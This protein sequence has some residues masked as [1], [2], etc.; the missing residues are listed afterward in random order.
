MG[1]VITLGRTVVMVPVTIV[2]QIVDGAG[3]IPVDEEG[4]VDP[5]V[6]TG[7]GLGC[8]GVTDGDSVGWGL[9][10]GIDVQ[11]QCRAAAAA[12]ES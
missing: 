5:V 6:G 2:V 3:A 1:E 7:D 9:G 8:E 11:P 12:V 10:R 4:I